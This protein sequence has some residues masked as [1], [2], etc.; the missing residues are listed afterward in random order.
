MAT[1]A[2]KKIIFASRGLT[3]AP[4]EHFYPPDIDVSFSHTAY[5]LTLSLAQG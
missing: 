1:R 2:P 5:G 3:G 4:S